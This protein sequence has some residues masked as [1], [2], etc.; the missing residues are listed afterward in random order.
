MRLPKNYSNQKIVAEY[1][2]E[3]IEMVKA[4]GLVEI[5]CHMSSDGGLTIDK[6]TLSTIIMVLLIAHGPK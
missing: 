5:Q 1:I 6:G 3:N 2:N 4:E